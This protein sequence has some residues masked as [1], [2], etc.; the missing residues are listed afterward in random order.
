M[1]AVIYRLYRLLGE[2]TAVVLGLAIVGM[3]I[4][5]SV[6]DKQSTDLTALR[7]NIKLWFTEAFNGR[8]AEFG[9]LEV[10]WLPSRDQIIV[11]IEDASR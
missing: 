9:K 10:S 8:D 6:L 3:W 4:A 11:T 1:A 2:V 7:P 5:T